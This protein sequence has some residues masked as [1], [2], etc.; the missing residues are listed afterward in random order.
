MES[1]DVAVH[2]GV[3][4]ERVEEGLLE[5]AVFFVGGCSLVLDAEDLFPA[6]PFLDNFVDFPY[7]EERVIVRVQ[8]HD[9]RQF[10]GYDLIT[11]DLP[12]AGIHI[13]G[14]HFQGDGRCSGTVFDL[15]LV[16]QFRRVPIID[17]GFLPF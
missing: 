14:D 16:G 13:V 4:G 11:K 1:V 7:V 9:E 5:L 15:L 10:H 12:I 2:L 17:P 6:S 8:G 3:G